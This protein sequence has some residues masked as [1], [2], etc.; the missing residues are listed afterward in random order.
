MKFSIRLVLGL[1]LIGGTIGSIPARAQTILTIEVG[2]LLPGN[3]SV[4]R[5]D[6]VY[7]IESGYSGAYVAPFVNE[8]LAASRYQ[9][10]GE[11]AAP[12]GARPVALATDASGNVFVA[13]GGTG[14]VVY[15]VTADGTVIPLVTGDAISANGIAVDGSDNLYITDAVHNTV[16]EVL[17]AGGYATMKTLGTGFNLP[18]G[19]AVDAGGNVFVAD[20]GNNA[21]K[22]ILAASDYASIQ[23]LGT[24]FDMPSGVALDASDNVYVADG[25]NSAVKEI[26]ATGGYATVQAVGSGFFAPVGI[27]LDADGNVFVTDPGTTAV[28]EILATPPALLASVLPGGRSVPLGSPATF[29]ATM[30]NSGPSALQDCGIALLAGTSPSLTLGYQTTDASTNLPV[31]TPNAPVTIPGN[32]GSQSFIVSVDSQTTFSLTNL[33]LSFACAGAPPAPIML[34]VDTVDLAWSSTPVPDVVAL[35]AT[36]SNNGIVELEN[37]V[38]AFA[39]ASIN[40]GAAA[41]ITVNAG[42]Y[43]AYLPVT[44]TVCQTDSTSGQCLAPP[45]E[46]VSLTYASGATPTFSVFLQATGPIPLAPASSRVFVYFAGDSPYAVVG[47]TSVAIEAE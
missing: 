11:L 39:V 5:N 46:T 20:T 45:A 30:I 26:M 23:T 10:T 17:A 28:K 21:V 13:S 8:Y 16:V 12:T 35:V 4:D 38:G 19:I 24:G 7:V 29:F 1:L 40:L 6:N 34:G 18:S 44:A 25:G 37:G 15:E 2:G 47:S 27:A 42:T 31:G 22:E 43:T 36:E 9:S 14:P 33:P 41:T 32:D 3:V